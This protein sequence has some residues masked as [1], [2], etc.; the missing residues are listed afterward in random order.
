MEVMKNTVGN[1]PS[2]YISPALL[3]SVGQ[4]AHVVDGTKITSHNI[5]AQ[6]AI[7]KGVPAMNI[8]ELQM[9]CGERAKKSGWHA[10]RPDAQN[11]SIGDSCDLDHKAYSNAL[12]NWQ[13]MKIMLMVSELAEGV[14]ELRAGNLANETYYP[15]GARAQW[16]V[17]GVPTHKPE[18]LPSELA[19]TVIRVLDFCHTEKIDLQSM[20]QEKLDFNQTRGIKHGGKAV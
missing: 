13:G 1:P 6:S 10:D 3:S 16:Y 18:G 5:H 12:R 11:F 14:E 15:D 20:I 8:A 7:R 19:D 17:D 9:L 2:S 4:V